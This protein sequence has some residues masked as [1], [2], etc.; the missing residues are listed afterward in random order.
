MQ[1][2]STVIGK[3]CDTLHLIMAAE[4]ACHCFEFEMAAH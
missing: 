1:L 2:A 4:S 3:A